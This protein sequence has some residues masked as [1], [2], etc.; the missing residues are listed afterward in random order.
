[1]GF[2][3]TDDH[4]QTE[5]WSKSFVSG[6][7]PKDNQK[8]KGTIVAIYATVTSEKVKS[9][10]FLTKI[11]SGNLELQSFVTSEKGVYRKRL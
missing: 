9:R 11:W 7:E 5:T 2:E 4:K 6:F 3:P 1:M 8:T 10:K